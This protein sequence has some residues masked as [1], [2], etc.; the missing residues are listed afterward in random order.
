MQL[1]DLKVYQKAMALGDL[2]WIIVDRWNYFQKDSFG[3]QLIRAVDS[4]AANISEGY[5]RFHF[6]E[7][8]HFNYIARG[9]L[10]ETRTWI[11][12]AKNRNL[13]KDDEYSQIRKEINEIG[14]M[15]NK[16]ISS[17]K[18][19]I[20]SEPETFYGLDNKLD[21]SDNILPYP[22]DSH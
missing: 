2:C 1:D 17:I 3:K 6:K 8:I 5:G 22:E 20:A 7:N 19:N 12:K 10:F 16:Y 4:I 18:G 14:R 11:E 9:S 21:L 15:L 13:L